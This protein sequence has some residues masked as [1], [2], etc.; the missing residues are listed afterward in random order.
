MLEIEFP[1]LFSVLHHEEMR[2]SH[3]RKYTRALTNTLTDTLVSY[4]RHVNSCL[5]FLSHTLVSCSCLI[6]LSHTLA[7]L[8]SYSCLILLSHALATLV[9]YSRHVRDTRAGDESALHHDFRVA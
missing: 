7:T 2:K 1:L 4:S 3:F 6:L 5:I 9:S 8:V